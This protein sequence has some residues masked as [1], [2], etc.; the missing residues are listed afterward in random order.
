MANKIQDMKRTGIRGVMGARWLLEGHRRI[1]KTTSSVVVFLNSPVS[2][3][4]Q[5]GQMKM[6]VRG[7]WLPVEAYNFERGKQRPEVS[8]ED[9]W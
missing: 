2:F 4:V 7:R 8:L 3:I 1:G 9:V 6:K 5:G